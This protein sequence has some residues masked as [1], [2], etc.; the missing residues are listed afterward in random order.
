MNSETSYYID[1]LNTRYPFD[2]A[3]RNR[4]IKKQFLELMNSKGKATLS[5]VDIGAGTGSNCR[6]WI[7]RIPQHQH[8]K[9]IEQNPA[10]IKPCLENLTHFA[11][12]QGYHREHHPAGLTMVA[13]EKHIHIDLLNVSLFEVGIATDLSQTDAITANAV[14]DLLTREQFD[15]FIQTITEH[16]VIFLATLNYG[17][18]YFTPEHSY[19]QE[20]IDLY[21]QHMR[22]WQPFGKSMGP[23][24]VQLMPE[25]LEKYGLKVHSLESYWQILRTDKEML[26]YYMD[27]M[28]SALCDMAVSDL[29]KAKLQDWLTLKEETDQAILNVNHQDILAIPL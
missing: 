8:W 11:I 3:G 12:E 17:G 18:M 25:I 24:C 15:N 13:G 9:L 2:A 16:P 26:N 1:W 14:F 5:L 28:K 6:Y 7:D 19:D 10:F 23:A 4:E 21:E 29:E 22:R 27:F 20:F